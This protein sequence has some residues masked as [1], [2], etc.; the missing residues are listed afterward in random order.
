M[1]KINQALRFLLLLCVFAL[2]SC[3]YKV[4]QDFP[5]VPTKIGEFDFATKTDINLSVN[6]G[7]TFPISFEVYLKDPILVQNGTVVK[8]ESLTPVFKAITDDNGA[9]EGPVLLPTYVKEIYLYTQY[10]GVPTSVRLAVDGKT[11]VFDLSE[12]PAASPTKSYGIAR[13]GQVIGGVEFKLLG[14]WNEMGTP[15]NMLTRRVLD[16]SLLNN[17]MYSLPESIRGLGSMNDPYNLLKKDKA[18]GDIKLLKN[19]KVNVLFMH[20]GASMRNTLAYYCYPTNNPPKSPDEVTKIIAI[21]NCSYAYSGGE[22]SSGDCV[23]LKYWNGKEFV[24]EFPAGTTIG[25]CM[26]SNGFVLETGNINTKN[27][28]YYT[29]PAFNPEVSEKQHCVALYDKDDKV[30]AIGFEDQHREKLYN[31]KLISDQDFNDLVFYIETS[32][33]ESI[34][35]DGIPDI[36]ENPKPK[37]N[38]SDNYIEYKGSLTFE[39]LWPSQGD[40]DMN[41]LVIDYH[42]K[43]YRNAQN[44]ITKIVDKFTPRWAGASNLNGFGYQIGVSNSMINSVKIASDY[45][46][47][48]S[49]VKTDGKGLE[50][51]QKLP[52]IVLF[53]NMKAIMAQN[54]SYPNTTKSFT[55]T[56]EFN[57]PVTLN[58]LTPPPYNPFIICGS[59]SA[60]NPQRGVEVHLPNKKPTDLA[61]KDQLGT[62]SDASNPEKGVYYISS[63]NYMFGLDLP[64]QFDFPGDGQNIG[65]AY[66]RFS[67]W[68]S[69]GGL[70]DADWYL[71]AK[72]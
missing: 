55:V 57:S 2:A 71:D 1:K 6:Y 45:N 39:D 17:I 20:E 22:L 10:M 37:P 7:I 63:E 49:L 47:N 62:K 50:L 58:S 18:I 33:D 61:D 27:N 8:D 70:N 4:K 5:E 72:K 28:I 54:G 53:E 9:F 23:Q 24:E 51:N 44:Q 40:Y 60:T 14:E 30:I 35:T 46:S 66:S 42:S 48:L 43:H 34:D 31:G 3:V 52:T 25:W 15:K 26:I 13:A 67:S 11:V 12:K 21:P 56:V 41:D 69:S 32:V 29:N 65:K 38:P 64:V 36:V 59:G 68:V 19:T 16:G